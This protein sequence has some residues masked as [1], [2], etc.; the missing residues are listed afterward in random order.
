MVPPSSHYIAPPALYDV[1]F[2]KNSRAKR[3]HRVAINYV[4]WAE[5][6]KGELRG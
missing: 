4:P 3:V 5:R 2:N 1:D 6:I